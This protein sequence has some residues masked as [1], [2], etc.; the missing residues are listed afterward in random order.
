MIPPKL[1]QELCRATET[2][3]LVGDSEM[4]LALKEILRA[5]PGKVPI[6]AKKVPT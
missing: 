5:M 3:R 1:P 2:A 4:L 6:A